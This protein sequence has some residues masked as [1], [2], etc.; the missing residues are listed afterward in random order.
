MKV[1]LSSGWLL[2]GDEVIVCSTGEEGIVVKID[3]PT[4]DIISEYK[5][6]IEKESDR[7]SSLM[8]RTKHLRL[9]L[10][11]PWILTNLR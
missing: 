8:K 7:D 10:V 4:I 5:T 1:P 6:A 3:G 2:V 11:M 9:L